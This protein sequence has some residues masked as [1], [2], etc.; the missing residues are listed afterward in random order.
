MVETYLFN[1]IINSAK[2]KLNL[3]FTFYI[4]AGR[5]IFTPQ[6]L[7]G[8]ANLVIETKYRENV[9]KVLVKNDSK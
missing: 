9:Y 4:Q 5:T 3:V 8:D 7:D 2:A 6:P 1:Q